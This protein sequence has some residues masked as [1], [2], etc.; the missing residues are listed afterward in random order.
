LQKGE[1]MI[2]GNYGMIPSIL[3]HHPNIKAN[4]K[5]LYSEITAT[6]EPSGYCTKNNNYFSK[7]LNLS[8]TSISQ[9]IKELRL[10]GFIKV[11]IENEEN[12]L[13]FKK[14]YISLT[15]HEFT[16]GVL[17]Q[18]QD[19]HSENFNGVSLNNAPTLPLDQAPPV[20]SEQTILLDNNIR[21]IYTSNKKNK[22][23]LHREI[24]DKQ[25][26]FIKTIV[27]YFYST[28]N[29]K[30][31]NMVKDWNNE[32]VI[33]ESVNTIFDLIVKD[34]HDSEELKNVL[35]WALQDKFWHKNIFS[36][37]ALRSKSSNGVT[38]YNN[39]LHSYKNQ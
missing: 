17:K 18:I 34:G 16:V 9:F 12:T 39:I 6:I 22:V 20:N 15:P 32:S 10:H 26:E 14:R 8:K 7:V 28:Q 38:K 1:Q 29:L 30:F 21:Y 11:V 3:R 31:P 25:L 2:F 19:P 24:T 27:K 23:S 37:R 35:M 36:I 4:S 5:L 13:K 33:N